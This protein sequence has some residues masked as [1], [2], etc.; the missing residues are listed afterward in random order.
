MTPLALG[1]IDSL[2]L[3]CESFKLAFTTGLLT[4]VYDAKIPIAELTALLPTEGRYVQRDGA[5]WIPSG[6]AAFDP[7]NHRHDREGRTCEKSFYWGHLSFDFLRICT[8]LHDFDP[9]KTKMFVN[10]GAILA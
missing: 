10:S 6:R 5:W 1:A 9:F 2:A 7:G 8:V 4:G 3:P